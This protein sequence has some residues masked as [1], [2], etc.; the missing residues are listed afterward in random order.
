[1]KL[2]LIAYLHGA[3]GAERQIVLLANEMAKRNHEVHLIVL[4]EN[5]SHYHL[6]E[7]VN[8]HD[9]TR[10]EGGG[11][12]RIVK[13]FVAMRK[14]LR[15]IRPDVTISYNLQGAYFSLL[16][17]RKI[18][19][20]VLY[21]ERG[22]PYDDEYSGLLG[23]IRDVTCRHID[24]FVFQSEGARDFFRLT[25]KQMSIIIHNSVTVPQ[26]KYPMPVNRDK[27]IVTVGRLHPQKNPCLL[28]DAF[29]LISKEY[30]EMMLDFYGDGPLKEKIQAKVNGLG[31]SDRIHLMESRKDIF[32]CIYKAQLFVLPSDYEGM[33]N[34]LMEAMSLGIPCI[35]TD[36]R[37]GGARTLIANGINGIIVPTGNPSALAEKISFVLDNPLVAD[38]LAR[39]ARKLGQSHTNEFIFGKWESFL[40][41]LTER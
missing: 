5:N 19:G 41:S 35:S 28:V 25:K 23:V 31:L 11:I 10:N 34:A 7:Q 15:Y 27:R 32:D 33:P 21:S 37:P 16:I 6:L 17:G 4:C 22:D 12:F 39:E 38:G 36:C 40:M 29:A 26:D 2:A 3:G 8:V 20:K 24:A 14:Y 9:A 13:R 1:M 18:C 30:P